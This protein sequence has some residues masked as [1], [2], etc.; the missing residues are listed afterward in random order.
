MK[1]EKIS[2]DFG[3]ISLNRAILREVYIKSCVREG[4]IC[5]TDSE[6]SVT[7]LNTWDMSLTSD[8]LVKWTTCR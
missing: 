7:E 2:K 6:V 4:N 8:E 3:N 5:V 1:N